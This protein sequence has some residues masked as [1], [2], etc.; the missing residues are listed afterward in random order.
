MGYG[1]WDQPTWTNYATT[2]IQ[3]K[4][5]E[6]IY[7]ERNLHSDLDPKKIT[8]RESCDS[9]INPNSTAIIVGQD[10]TG[11]MAPVLHSLIES[12]LPTLFTEIYDRK[13]VP[14]PH[15]MLMGI[16]DVLFDSAPLQVT[17]FEADIR[18][19]DQLKR[20]YLEQGGG[21]NGYESYILAWLFAAQRT[22]IDCYN[23]RKKKGYLFTVGDESI[24][25]MLKWNDVNRV[26]GENT[27]SLDMSNDEIFKLAS[28]QYDIF[29]IMVEQGAHMRQNTDAVVQSWVDFLGERAL[30]LTDYT[31]LAQVI[32]SAIQVNEGMDMNDV[33]KSWD[34][35]TAKVVTDAFIR[36][37]VF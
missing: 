4:T 8:M 29:H 33:A 25:P 26:M 11:S 14:D 36:E 6:A 20:I 7:N 24:T 1:K 18:I 13:P 12:G 2:H 23:K 35:A 22:K 9:D 19:A 27:I 28:Q 32:V 34:P 16:G 21:G 17:Q 30:R 10:V 3:G 31:K 37:V 15:V 5:V